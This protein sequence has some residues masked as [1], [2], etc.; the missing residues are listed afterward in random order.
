[1]VPAKIIRVGGDSLTEMVRA[2]SRSANSQ[3]TVQPADFSAND[4]FHVQV[5]QLANNIWLSGA[6][7]RWMYERARGS[8][9]AAEVKAGLPKVQLRQFRLETPKARRFSKTDLA[10][11]INAWEGYPNW[12]SYGSQKNFQHFMQRLK[13]EH[14]DGFVPDGCD[15]PILSL[16]LRRRPLH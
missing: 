12:V 16:C 3:N 14:P 4:A 6:S 7:G 9:G 11:T 1:M 5:E 2:I 13:L 15:E 10:T 8:Y